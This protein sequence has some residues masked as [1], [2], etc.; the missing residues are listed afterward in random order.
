MR[1]GR[2]G[3]VS[4]G[5]TDDWATHLTRGDDGVWLFWPPAYHAA[6]S[7]HILRAIADYLDRMNSEEA[8]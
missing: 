4:A 3:T 6:Y 8:K 1:H 5:V 7:A 2:E